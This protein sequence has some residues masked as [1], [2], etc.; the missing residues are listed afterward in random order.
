MIDAVVVRLTTK[1]EIHMTKHRQNQ[2]KTILGIV[3]AGLLGLLAV[4][5]ETQAQAL[6]ENRENY[7]CITNTDG[8]AWK[9]EI[10]YTYSSYSGGRE[11]LSFDESD[12][13]KIASILV[14]EH[15]AITSINVK[16]CVNLTNLVIQPARS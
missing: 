11:S 4:P 16:G 6:P 3:A 1:Q 10:R 8:S 14:P 5:P 7:A 2:K 13:P 9:K 15:A 12:K